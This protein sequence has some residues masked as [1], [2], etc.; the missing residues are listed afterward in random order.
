MHWCTSKRDVFAISNPLLD[1]FCSLQPSLS[2]SSSPRSQPSWFVPRFNRH[3][4][5]MYVFL[6]R[7]NVSQWPPVPYIH[8]CTS[9]KLSS[10]LH[11]RQALLHFGRHV[12]MCDQRCKPTRWWLVAL[13]GCVRLSNYCNR[14]GSIVCHLFWG[15]WAQVLAM[16]CS[17][18][19]C[20]VASCQSHPRRVSLD[21]RIQDQLQSMMNNFRSWVGEYHMRLDL[22]LRSTSFATSIHWSWGRR[23]FEVCGGCLLCF[24]W[25]QSG[26]NW[27]W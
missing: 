10:W 27:M 22:S 3:L 23:G 20:L 18:Q 9:A 8:T 7:P 6:S 1:P 16:S 11:S 14:V 12:H 26:S 24:V 13:L 15:S 17:E 21:P 19:L 4:Y 25:W 2:S 5:S